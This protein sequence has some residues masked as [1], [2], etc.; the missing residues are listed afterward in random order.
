MTL[1]GGIPPPAPYP[2]LSPHY[3]IALP[4]P[5]HFPNISQPSKISIQAIRLHVGSLHQEAVTRAFDAG[6]GDSPPRT[7]SP[8]V[9]TFSHCPAR[10]PALP[11]HFVILQH[12]HSSH[13]TACGIAV[14]RGGDARFLTLVGGGFPPP[15]TIPPPVSTLSH[16]PA[17]PPALPKHFTTF[18][19]LHSS[20]Q[21]A[22]GI[23]VSRGGDAHL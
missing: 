1:G 5:Q 18:Q 23:A 21:T 11:K 12:L 15:R 9:S 3:P 6:G 7:I 19:N 10:P 8:P 22:C 17:R 16:C 20:H 14:S 2:L 13:Q 4:D